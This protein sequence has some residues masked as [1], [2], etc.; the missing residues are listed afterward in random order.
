MSAF[1]RAKGS[2]RPGDLS[3]PG[4][5]SQGGGHRVRVSSPFPRA[6][7]RACDHS[8]GVTWEGSHPAERKVECELRALPGG[9]GPGAK[10]LLYQ[11][12]GRPTSRQVTFQETLGQDGA[13]C[14]TQYPP[15]N[16]KPKLHPL[17]K[18]MERVPCPSPEGMP[19]DDKSG[20]PAKLEG[21]LT[22]FQ[23]SPQNGPK[24]CLRAKRSPKRA[25]TWMPRDP[26][27][28]R[29]GLGGAPSLPERPLR[30]APP[31]ATEER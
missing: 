22:Q 12:Q 13:G 21:V 23:P 20:G 24:R 31:C 10:L 3:V 19:T 11:P 2:L 18:H 16:L 15:E 9:W 4:R 8:A 28:C 26:R 17:P 7:G 14:Q 29:A 25:E 30:G 1:Q 5:G 6:G 27:W